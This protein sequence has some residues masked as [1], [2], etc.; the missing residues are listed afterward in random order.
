MLAGP[1]AQ[2][3]HAA[4][5]VQRVAGR[6][7]PG[8][9]D[10]HAVRARRPAVRGRAGRPSARHQGRRAAADAVPD[11]DRQLRRR[12]RS[13]RRGLR[14][15]LRHQPYVY[16]Y[17]TATTPAFTT[18]SAASPPTAT[19]PWPG[20]EVVLLE[21]D[22]LSSATNHNGGAL[23][24]APTASSTPPSARTPTARNAQSMNNLLGKM[25]RLNA[26]GTH[27]DRQPVLRRPP[28]ART[29]RSG[30]SAS[31]IPSRSR[32]T[33][34]HADVHQ[35][36]RPEHLGRDQR[37]R[38]RRQLR[39]AGR[40]KGRRP[41]RV[42]QPAIRLQPLRRRAA[43]SPAAPSTR[44]RPRSSR[45]TIS[46][47]YFFA[48]YCGG[49]IRKL[50]PAAATRVVTFATG[51]RLSGRSQGRRRRQP[52]LSGAR[53]RAARPASSTGSRTAPAR[54]ASRTHPSSQTVAPGA[55]VT[56]SVRAS[57]PPPLR[58]QWQRNGANISGA[59]AQ[60]YTIASSPRPTTARVS[61]P[62]SATTSATS[63]SNEAVLTVTGNQ[64][65]TGTITQPA[66]GTLYSGGSVI[67]YAGTATDP[68]DGTLPASAFTW[69]VDFHHDTHSH[70][71]I[72]PTTGAHER[73]VHDS[74]DRA[75]RP[76][77]GTASILTVRDSAGADAHDVQRDVL[78]RKVQPDA[79]DQP[80]RSAAAARRPAV[81]DAAH[82]RERRRH[83]A[84]PRGA[85]HAGV[86]RDDL[87]VRV[88]VRRRRGQP[89]HL[90]AGGEH[91]LHRDLS[92][93]HR[94]HRQRPLGHL[95][96]QHRLHR[97][98]RVTRV[99]PTVDFAWGTG[100]PAAAIG[101]DT[102]SARW[103]GQVEAAVHRHLHV[104]HA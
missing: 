32:S 76:T 33:R 103:T 70:P 91:D 90:D 13:A 42:R 53:H 40:P 59:T 71:F 66:A 79:C 38:R 73:F 3:S 81:A 18:A 101:A 80:G 46:N 41:T 28:P 93:R 72:A 98:D 34:R 4:G 99:D 88:L 12:A 87:R 47:D 52:V 64:P 19:S 57:G 6:E 1:P 37:R 86:G 65:P 17:Y 55:S 95:L 96:Q 56:F 23:P 30:R 5:R 45:P 62:S 94:R 54:P 83:R 68:E 84:R 89:Q 51:H 26:D 2:R 35:R 100:S 67:S 15:G 16:V 29:A 75:H 60:D 44:R 49:W 69:R 48:D 31:A 22:N 24:S 8:E 63:L 61:A 11:T 25:L 74:D 21:L 43:R 9:P 27:P 97:H 58:Y 20:S 14:P 39:L 85:C 10:R 92:S 7:R 36:R 104:L 102:F 77:S 82:V 50:D 78:P